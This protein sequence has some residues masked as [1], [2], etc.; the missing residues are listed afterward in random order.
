[1]NRIYWQ[2][3]NE[4]TKNEIF[5]SPTELENLTVKLGDLKNS[6]KFVFGLNVGTI[7]ATGF[8]VFNNPYVEFKGIEQ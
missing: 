6:A 8:D 7:E 2:R 3:E 1:M 5:L 4:Y